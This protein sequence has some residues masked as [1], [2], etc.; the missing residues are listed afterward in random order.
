MEIKYCCICGNQISGYGNNPWPI[1]E[2]GECCGEC[3]SMVVIPARIK[4]M[5]NK[6]EGKKE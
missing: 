6:A 4:N 2:S 3:N 1:K 5:M